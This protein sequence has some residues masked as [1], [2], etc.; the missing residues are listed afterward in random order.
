MVT[1]TV[2]LCV[3]LSSTGK[4]SDLPEPEPVCLNETLS[5][6]LSDTSSLSGLD[7]RIASYMRQ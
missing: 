2:G 1:L 3:S 5:N 7:A 6:E 4:V